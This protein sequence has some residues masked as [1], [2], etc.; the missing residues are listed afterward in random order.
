[1]S[2]SRAGPFVEVT[3]RFGTAHTRS[4]TWSCTSLSA[5]AP[6]RLRSMVFPLSAAP[7]ICSVCDSVPAITSKATDRRPRSAANKPTVSK[8]G[9]RGNTP[10][11]GTAPK[12]GLKPRTPWQAAGTRTDPAVSVPRAKGTASAAT[13]AADPELDPA[14][15]RSGSI[16]LITRPKADSSP[17]IPYEYSWQYVFATGIAPASSNRDTTSAEVVNADPLQTVEFIVVGYPA[18]SVT[19]FA[20]NGIPSS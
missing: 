3:A 10:S 19:S 15:H 5:D 20:A 11:T 6:R 13:I 9:E 2:S 1:M 18:I 14:V 16:G 12:L 7:P 4:V 8:A 17:R